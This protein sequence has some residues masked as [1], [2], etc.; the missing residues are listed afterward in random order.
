MIKLKLIMF[1]LE[2]GLLAK[3]KLHSMLQLSLIFNSL[4]MIN[5]HKDIHYRLVIM[6]QNLEKY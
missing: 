2:I 3:G 6:V 4:K 5:F 1:G